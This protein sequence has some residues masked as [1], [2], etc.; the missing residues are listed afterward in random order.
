[1]TPIERFHHMDPVTDALA[2]SISSGLDASGEP[3]YPPRS[4]V[5]LVSTSG[6]VAFQNKVVNVGR[7]YARARVRVIEISGLTHIY[8]AEER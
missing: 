5:R 8:Y 2:G 1:M 3:V 4:I 7:R 6:D